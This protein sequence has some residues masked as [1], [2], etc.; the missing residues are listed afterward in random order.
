[1]NDEVDITFL[2]EKV[3]QLEKEN[4]EL[5]EEI[6]KLRPLEVNIPTGCVHNSEDLNCV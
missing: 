6:A 4:A 2:R 3:Q 1:M 5:R